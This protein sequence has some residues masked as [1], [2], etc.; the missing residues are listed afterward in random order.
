MNADDEGGAGDVVGFRR[1][2]GHDAGKAVEDERDA[3]V[4]KLD[5]LEGADEL[6]VV[7]CGVGG[8]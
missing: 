1:G 5:E 7:G 6:L 4:Q 2:G 3:G 8:G